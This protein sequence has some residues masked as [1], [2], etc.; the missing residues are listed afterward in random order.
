MMP[1]FSSLVARPNESGA[2]C[3]F[4]IIGC[5]FAQGNLLAAWLA[6]GKGP[7]LRR[8]GIHWIIAGGLY[9]IWLGG[10]FLTSLVGHTISRGP[11]NASEAAM[12]TALGVGLVSI[13]AQLPLWIVRQ[14]FGWRLIKE[15]A[16]QTQPIEPPLAIRDLMLATI[17]V[18]T[19]LALARLA[20]GPQKQRELWTMWTV[21]FTAASVISTISLLPAG[22]ILLRGETFRRR[23]PW[24]G[25]YA[26]ALI[27]LPWIIVLD[28]WWYGTAP[29]PPRPLLVG[30]S[31][32]MFTFAATLML[33]ARILRDR[34]YY[35]VWGR[36]R[37]SRV[38]DYAPAA[39]DR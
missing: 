23:L 32:L 33:T 28:V 27:A 17:I 5:V 10:L 25:V 39:T 11:T 22:A 26:A 24:G 34:G 14:W 2:A 36:R 21:F 4:G 1:A 9:L 20:P 29:V 19:S 38:V 6:W 12:T 30:L 35:L 18:A 7:F 15:D 31:S 37:P 3:T 16:D 13:A 8:L